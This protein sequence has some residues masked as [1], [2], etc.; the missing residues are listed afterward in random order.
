MTGDKLKEKT[1]A[2]CTVSVPSPKE[3]SL[4]GCFGD[5]NGDGQEFTFSMDVMSMNVMIICEF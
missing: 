4:I 1:V 2:E 3:K 5:G